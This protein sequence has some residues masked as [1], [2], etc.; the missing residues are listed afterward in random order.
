MPQKGYSLH[1]G[2]NQADQSHY[3]GLP[4]L[5]CCIND[6]ELMQDIA[7]RYGYERSIIL[8]NEEATC[9]RLNQI[10]T[11]YSELL[12]AGDLF[13]LTYSGHGGQVEDNTGDETDAQ[14]ETWC[15]YDRQFLDDELNQALSLFKEGVRVLIFSDSCHSGTMA[16]GDGG[17]EQAIRDAIME[18]LEGK[19]IRLKFMPPQVANRISQEQADL[20][21]QARSQASG[22]KKGVVKASVKLFAAC[23]DHQV[24]REGKRYSHFTGELLR[25][26]RE[27]PGIEDYQALHQ[28]L[29]KT[30]VFQTP[31][32]FE[33][34][35]KDPAFDRSPPFVIEGIGQS[36]SIDAAPKVAEKVELLLDF[37]EG[38]L[39][40]SSLMEKLAPDYEL[41]GTGVKGDGQGAALESPS[42]LLKSRK[43][44]EKEWDLAYQAF[45][46]IKDTHPGVSVEPNFNHPF[47]VSRPTRAKSTDQENIYLAAW[48][49]PQDFAGQVQ[50]EFGWHL[51]DAFSELKSARQLVMEDTT[52]EKKI[53]I[54]HIDTGYVPAHIT[55]PEFVLRGLAVSFVKG[56]RRNPGIDIIR[57]QQLGLF[58]QDGHGLGTL[59]ILAGGKIEKHESYGGFEGYLGAA[60]FA[61][62]IPIR[63]SDTVALFSTK[64]FALAIE[65]A[66]DQGCE[67]VTMSMAGLPSRKW[68]R[69]VDKAYERGVTIV[70]AAGNNWRKGLMRI[71]PNTTLYPA[72]YQRVIAATGACINHE[73]YDFDINS[74]IVGAKPA[75]GE[76]MQGNWGPDSCMDTAIAAYTPNLPWAM[77]DQPYPFSRSGGGTSAATPQV[78]AA[79]ALWIVKHRE[80]LKRRGYSGTWKQVEAVRQALFRTADKSYI[81]YHKYYGQGILKARKALEFPCPDIL[82]EHQAGKARGSFL[83]IIGAM[84]RRILRKKKKREG[85]PQEEMVSL[86]ILQLIHRDPQLFPYAEYLNLEDPTRPLFD[87]EQ[88]EEAFVQKLK[89]SEMASDFLKNLLA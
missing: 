49:S 21:R 59:A 12:E 50:N 25:V 82:E 61:E 67:V 71:A 10:L 78:A 87:N 40:D 55:T 44:A 23:L 34:G 81:G 36:V 79:V 3:G 14:D 13:L 77:L 2:V 22:E 19:G 37:E 11:E 76:N 57:N 84:L 65:Y 30:A 6:A 7:R 45:D 15:L 4:E 33:V 74:W 89:G 32:Y 35:E 46:E 73:P 42:S 75:I 39:P 5:S 86:E 47:Y 43:P 62:V 1:I 64:A 70:S 29:L 31:N 28:A 41:E 38:E 83:P 56:E 68:A 69:A 20:Y 85:L 54:A 16:R 27:S 60:P 53:R 88:Q 72:R 51:E 18:L 26:L 80:E 8:R 66:L 24:A 63:I 9:A 48:P 52:L 58:E 17:E